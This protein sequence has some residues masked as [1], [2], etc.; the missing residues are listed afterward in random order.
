MTVTTSWYWCKFKR[1][2]VSWL[3]AWTAIGVLIGTVAALFVPV[4]IFSQL[5]WLFGALSLGF[6]ACFRR[7]IVSI[8]LITLCGVGV[9]IYVGST[10]LVELGHLRALHGTAQTISGT[11]RD[12]TTRGP[13]GDQRLRL[14]NLTID[15]QPVSGNLWVSA[16]T[17]LEIK[18]SD[19][20]TVNGH[21]DEGFGT[22][23]ASMFRASVEEVV[24]PEPG[25]IARVARDNF[26]SEVA[27]HMSS[28]QSNL[29]VSFLVGQRSSLPSDIQD[30][31]RDLGLVHLVVASGFHLSIVVRF[32]RR[33]FSPWS[34]YLAL[35]SS[36]LLIFSFL[37]LTGFSTSM[38]RASLV[39]SLS[40]LAW[41]VGRSIHPL[42]LLPV[43]AA[44]TVIINPVYIWSDLAWHLSF[45]AF[46][47]VIVLAPL[48]QKY[49]WRP[50][51]DP[52]FFRY[53]VVATFSAQLLTFPIIALTFEQYSLL[54]IAANVL[55]LPLVP[56]VM[57]GTFTTGVSA[58]FMPFLAHAFGWITEMGLRYIT[59]VVDFLAGL[60]IATSS[61]TITPLQIGLYYVVMFTLM[62]YLQRTTKHSLRSENPV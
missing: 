1:F 38:V 59:A 53:L 48:L 28:P 35:I 9:G 8:L 36:L 55:V 40:L 18:R 42:V 61:I 26:S 45:A 17:S 54:A 27:K 60:P 46:T 52:G 39:T 2:H 19:R 44:T 33:S 16:Y 12:D 47:G 30:M 20:V 56:L 62:V 43:V 4:H 6:I 23:Q 37:L 11:V 14:D 32:S 5:P 34:K 24:R 7:S 3:F 25:D 31:F 22:V 50:D 29:G 10:T 15:E 57:L 49:F 21:I 58:F 51:K 13:S 41:Y